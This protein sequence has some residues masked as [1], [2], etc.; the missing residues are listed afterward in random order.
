MVDQ[1]YLRSVAERLRRLKVTLKPAEAP[2]TLRAAAEL[3]A[4]ARDFG[5]WA[6]EIEGKPKENGRDHLSS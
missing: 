1:E 3:E 4:L 2:Q 6:D 5:R